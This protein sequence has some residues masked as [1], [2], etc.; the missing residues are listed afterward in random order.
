MTSA[1]FEPVIPTI[2]LLRPHGHRIWPG[3]VTTGLF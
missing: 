1:G 2:N 3:N